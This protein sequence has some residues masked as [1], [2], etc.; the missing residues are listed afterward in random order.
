MCDLLK[1]GMGNKVGVTG[2]LF[3]G[4]LLHGDRLQYNGEL[5]KFKLT[6]YWISMGFLYLLSWVIAYILTALLLGSQKVAAISLADYLLDAVIAQLNQQSDS[7]LFLA[8][9]HVNY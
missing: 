2:Y 7:L 6:H 1:D 3:T 8:S 4:F 5:G 9:S